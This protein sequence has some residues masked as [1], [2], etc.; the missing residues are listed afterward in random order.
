MH[1]CMYAGHTA[2]H[3]PVKIFK[4]QPE[5]FA[6]WELIPDWYNYF[7]LTILVRRK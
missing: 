2:R 5:R 6:L 3:Y 4:V 7:R 1:A